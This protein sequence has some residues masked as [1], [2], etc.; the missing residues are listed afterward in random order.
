[1][2]RAVIPMCG[3]LQVSDW[4]RFARRRPLSKF[5]EDR[6]C[7]TAEA[8]LGADASQHGDSAELA[9][10][11]LLLERGDPTERPLPPMFA[12]VG[13]IHAFHAFVFRQQARQ[14]WDQQFAFIDRYL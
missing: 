12:G 2:P 4:Q 8:Y 1:M 7:E 10:P 11:L 14:C 3:M 5:L 9:D 6:L 13:E